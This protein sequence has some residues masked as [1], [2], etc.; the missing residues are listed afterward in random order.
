[1]NSNS[2]LMDC[3]IKMEPLDFA[4]LARLLGV[5]IVEENPDK[6]SENKIVARPFTD[7]F[8]DVMAKFDRLDR[9]KKR[10]I[11]RLVK[12]ANKMKRGHE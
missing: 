2:S 3:I 8:A 1:M 11:I 4:G 5:D 12:K 6:E 9:A 10:E 7:V